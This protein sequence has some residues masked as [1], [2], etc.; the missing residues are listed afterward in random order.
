[1]TMRRLRFDDDDNGEVTREHATKDD[2]FS[3][4]PGFSGNTSTYQSKHRT[5]RCITRWQLPIGAVRTATAV[6]KFAN[7]GDRQG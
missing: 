3:M 2:A 5:A 1:M 7:G 4:R 6:L